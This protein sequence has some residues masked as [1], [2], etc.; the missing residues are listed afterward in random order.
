LHRQLEHEDVARDDPR[1]LG[2]APR[3]CPGI[4]R[5]YDERPA[6]VR[7]ADHHCI[8]SPGGGDLRRRQRHR[9]RCGAATGVRSVPCIGCHDSPA[10][11][12]GAG[13]LPVDQT[14]DSPL[15][16]LA[17]NAA[18]QSTSGRRVQ[19]RRATGV[20]RRSVAHARRCRPPAARYLPGR[21]LAHEPQGIPYLARRAPAHLARKRIAGRV[22]RV[23]Q[24]AR[25]SH[26]SSFGVF[27]SFRSSSRQTERN[28]KTAFFP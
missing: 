27:R 9:L 22:R 20:C 21:R 7:R 6:G 24:S 5:Q 23:Q 25:K 13:I 1:R 8:P 19:P 11:T 14:F 26:R 18:G 4:R 17:A 12:G 15:A 28:K 16:S 10:A 3:D 2:P